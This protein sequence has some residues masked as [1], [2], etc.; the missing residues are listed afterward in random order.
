MI[1]LTYYQIKNLPVVLLDN[2]YD[3]DTY[4]KIWQELCFITNDPKKLRTPEEL[5]STWTL[6]NGKKVFLKNTQGVILDKVY[7]DRSI[8]NILIE[9]RKL[10]SKD[11]IDSLTNLHSFFRYLQISNSDITKVHYYENLDY[12]KEHWDHSIITA[13]FWAYKS[14]KSF[15]GGN[16]MFEDGLTVD[17]VNNRMAI[18]PSILTHE[19]TPIFIE[20]HLVGKNFG[21]YGIT[22]LIKIN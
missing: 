10:F 19:V 6:E 21:R 3:N 15:E 1:N 4:E 13:V 18:F 14:P 22:Q 11:I 20:D 7:N 12:Y 9:N 5:D 8:S 17:C 16:L 2:F